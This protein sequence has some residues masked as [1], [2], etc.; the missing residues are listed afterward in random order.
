LDDL[1]E[2]LELGVISE[3]VKISQST[4]SSRTCTSQ[5]ITSGGGGSSSSSSSSSS[6]TSTSSALTSLSCSLEQ[7]YGLV[8]ASFWVRSNWGR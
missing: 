1:A 2:L 8:A 3:E 7:I 6:T 5:Q 4:S